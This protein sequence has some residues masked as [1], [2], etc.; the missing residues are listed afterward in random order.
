MSAAAVLDA[1]W[2]APGPVLLTGPVSPDGDS[3]GACLALK[4]VLAQHGVHATVCGDASYRYRALPGIEEVVPDATIGPSWSTVVILDGDRHRLTPPVR[5]AFADA[6]VKGII[7]HHAS[8]V[9]DGYTHFWVDADA[10]STTEMLFR[11]FRERSIDYDAA[12]A[13]LL[14]VGVVFD[15]GCFRYSNTTPAVH[16]MAAELVQRGFDHARV[17]AEVMHERRPEALALAAEVYREARFVDGLAIGHVPLDTQRRIGM[18]PGDLEGLVE[19]LV[20]VHDVEVAVL[21]V[22]RSASEVKLSLRSRGA[23]DVAAVAQQLAPTGGGHQKAAG[24]SIAPSR[25]DEAVEAL[26][27]ALAVS[28]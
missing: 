21:F 13:E 28:G 23:V 19:S 15:T 20:H 25:V 3:L 24:V 22:H 7:D 4:R 12:V 10:A 11:A 26:H 17:C 5:A 18:V 27:A 6:S 8:T 14:Y 9:D 2:K 1:L 16:R